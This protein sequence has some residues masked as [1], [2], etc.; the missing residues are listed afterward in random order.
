MSKFYSSSRFFRNELTRYKGKFYS[1]DVVNEVFEWNG[2]IRT[3]S[4]FYKNFGEQYIS[5]AF[6][7]ARKIDP[8]TKLYINDYYIESIN[9]KSNDVYNLVKK[10]KSQGVPIDGVG[11][12]SHFDSGKIPKDFEKNLQRFTDL[13]VEVALTEL[14]IKIEM[15]ATEA[16]IKQQADDFASVYRI[17]QNNKKCVGVTVWGISDLYSYTRANQGVLWDE[18]FK[19]KLAVKEVEDVLK[20][21]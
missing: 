16:K 6:I 21:K 19:P 3:T 10:L 15:P 12:Q 5:D 4:I 8:S 17:C 18:N 1:W 13:G 14:D 9:A 2:T 11:F 20:G 7:L